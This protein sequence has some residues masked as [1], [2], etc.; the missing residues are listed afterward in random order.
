[1]VRSVDGWV[2]E[3]R[4]LAVRVLYEKVRFVV[5]FTRISN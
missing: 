5:A 2:G 4:M 1:M 3:T